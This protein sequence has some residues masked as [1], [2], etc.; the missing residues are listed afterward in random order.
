M[1]VGLLLTWWM[2]DTADGAGTNKE[3]M[4]KRTRRRQEP[5][6]SRRI[7][8]R[9]VGGDV[10]RSKLGRIGALVRD[11][12]H[13]LD[14]EGVLGVSQ[15]VADVDVGVHQSQLTGDEL[16][17][18]PAAG[19]AAAAAAAALAD[20]VVDHVL[21]AAALLR[22]TPLQPQGRLVDDGDDAPWS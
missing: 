3:E 17:V 18:V 16:H 21:P 8:T 7:L 6:R 9:L 20:D 13:S 15:Q 10:D 12:V 19:A 22:G 4:K 2:M 1:L 11:A 14:L 5:V